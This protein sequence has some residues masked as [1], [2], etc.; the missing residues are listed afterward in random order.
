MLLLTKEFQFLKVKTALEPL[1]ALSGATIVKV[2][3]VLHSAQLQKTEKYF[4][5]L[6]D[7]CDSGQQNCE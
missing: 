6:R 3:R 5:Q 1:L 2:E 7:I 4:P